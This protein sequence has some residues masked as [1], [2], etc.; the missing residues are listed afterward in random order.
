MAVVEGHEVLAEEDGWGA[1]VADFC[2]A[3]VMRLRTLAKEEEGLQEEAEGLV[4][5]MMKVEVVGF[6]KAGA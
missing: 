4:A 2:H 5:V 6:L 1:E 3:A